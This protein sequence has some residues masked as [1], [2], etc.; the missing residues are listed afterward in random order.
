MR[1]SLAAALVAFAFWL[2]PAAAGAQ[3]LNLPMGGGGGEAPLVI[4]ADD[5]LEWIPKEGRYIARGNARATRGKV[6]LRADELIAHYRQGKNGQ[7]QQIVRLDAAGRVKI[8]SVTKDARGRDATTTATGDVAVYH[9]EESVFVLRGKQLRLVSP[10]GV[11]TAR[12]SLEYWDKR[13]TAVARGKA[14]VTQGEQRLHADIL[15][16]YVATADKKGK[17]GGPGDGQ[18]VERVDAFGNVHVSVP[19]AIIRGDKGEYFPASSTATLR[20]NVKITSNQNQ[21]NGEIAR[22]NLKTG[23]YRLLG[24]RVKGLI[25]PDRTR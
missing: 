2:W 16:A 9:V 17:S 23:I 3:S 20:G 11:L 18:K 22:V 10:Q 8:T 14:V 19:N 1:Y 4:E 6:T 15:T 21:L 12:D 24:G 7:G 13:Q 25:T 5:G